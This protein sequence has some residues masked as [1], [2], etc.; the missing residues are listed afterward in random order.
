MGHFHI[1]IVTHIYLDEYY[2]SH[3]IEE[4][5]EAEGVM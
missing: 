2:Y 5:V 3:F 4:N 1:C